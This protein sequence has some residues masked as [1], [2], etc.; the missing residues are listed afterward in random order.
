VEAT[1]ALSIVVTALNNLYP[2]VPLAGWAI[3][4][5]FGLVHGF[6]FANVLIDLGLTDATL[7][8]S[9]LG[10][11]VGVELGQ[12]A[13]VLVFL[14]IAYL[15]RGTFLYRSLVLRMGSL[16]IA[17]IAGLWMYERLFNTEILGF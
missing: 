11:N 12:M 14:P 17:V 2:V 5:V 1:I 15:L 9:L 7:A 4:F 6:G 3:A 8:V 16:L 10:F 13:I